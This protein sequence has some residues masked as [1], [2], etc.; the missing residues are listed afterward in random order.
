MLKD[1][2]VDRAR[3]VALLAKAARAQRDAMLGHGPDKNLDG[4]NASRSDRNPTAALGY[5]PLPAED[6]Q[7]LALRE[8]LDALT[9]AERSELYVLRIG[10]GHLA[11]NK[12]HRGLEEAQSL[13]DATVTSS[14]I[15]DPDVH[16]HV[17]KG[18]YQAGLGS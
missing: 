16:D 2:N 13:G 3:F 10:Q 11:A 1:L 7:L 4:T 14:L 8:A 17:S 15:A 9:P 5:D 18:L 12:W 6:R